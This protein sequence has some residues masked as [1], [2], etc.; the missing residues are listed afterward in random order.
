MT[1]RL[2]P[3][4]DLGRDADRMTAEHKRRQEATV[5]DFLQ[6]FTA[7]G[8]D[9]REVQLLADEFGL[10]KTFVALATAYSL[11]KAV[12]SRPDLAEEVGLGRCHSAVVVVVPSGNRALAS[13][14]HQE[15]EA[16]RTRCSTDALETDWF[17]SKICE[18]AYDL[19]EPLQE[20][21]GSPTFAHFAACSRA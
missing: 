3:V 20:S 2:D 21:H 18:N 16:L 17:Q 4:L 9:R 6:A 10:G 1:L 19:A 7:A 11:L 13:K 15:V 12:R 8:R 14:W 5:N